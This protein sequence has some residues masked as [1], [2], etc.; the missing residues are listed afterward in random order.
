LTRMSAEEHRCAPRIGAAI[1]D[2]AGALKAL[3]AGRC[4]DHA[5]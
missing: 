3:A 2:F 4:D 1:I 5:A